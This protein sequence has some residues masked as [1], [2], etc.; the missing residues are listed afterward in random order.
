MPTPSPQRL[1]K[2]GSTLFPVLLAVMAVLLLVRWVYS[3]PAVAIMLR[4]PGLDD[5]PAK[6]VATVAVEPAK[7]PVPGEPLAGPGQPSTIA[8]AWPWFRGPDRDAINKETVRL[9][10]T[11]PDAGPKRL[12]TVPVG[13]G[14]AAAAVQGGRVY[15]LDY[16][17][18]TSSDL[19]RGLSPADRAAL[20]AALAAISPP[21]R[22]APLP[23]V[24]GSIDAAL[25][26]LFHLEGHSGGSSRPPISQ[27][28][29]D[30]LKR[31]IAEDLVQRRDVLVRS[32]QS[33]AID[34]IDESADTLRC[35]SLDDGREIWRNSYPVLIANSHG[36]SRTVPAVVGDCVITL[37]PKCQLAC[38]DAATGKSRWL[39]DLVQEYGATVPPWY[40]GQCPY[41]DTT[42]D[43]LIVAPGGKTLV[44]AVDYHTGQ[45]VWQSPN[46]RNW[47]MTHVSIVPMEFAG[48]RT[49]VYCGKGGVA[50]VA[51]DN[52]E[53]LWD[54][55][56]WQ[57]PMATCPSPVVVGEGRIFFCGGYNAGAMMLQLKQEGSSIVPQK[58]FKLDARLFG[59]EQQTPILWQ[60]HL[61]GVRQDDHQLVC[62]NLD[63]KVVWSSGQEKFG[64]GPYL[65]AD[66]LLLVLDDKG[67]LTAAEATP[68]AYRRMARA[69]VIEN[70]DSSWGP[71]ALVAGRLIVRDRSRMVC[72]DLAEH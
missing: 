42:T 55:D 50:G 60:Q 46:P 1:L 72:V 56:Q 20:G 6:P 17:H 16:V 25:A 19:L 37:G 33:G 66:G 47:A 3:G 38:W 18:D 22:D 51:A 39:I 11:W 71:M 12:W 48:R 27:A 62:M 29:Y 14:Y 10:R 7:K 52:G 69:Q 23:E 40:A 49:Y 34:D 9:A 5:V 65:I 26:P 45:V 54:T 68:A 67:V 4:V 44:M 70:G 8:A 63:G 41:I 2:Y 64:S 35:L 32:L 58:V 31:S 61:Y 21:S 28:E 59:C 30:A 43:R 15:V 13:E 36:M 57:V 53:L 24:A